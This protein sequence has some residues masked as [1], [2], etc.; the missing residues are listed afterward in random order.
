MH[1]HSIREKKGAYRGKYTHQNM[2]ELEKYS[3]DENR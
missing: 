1:Y 3:K 2:V